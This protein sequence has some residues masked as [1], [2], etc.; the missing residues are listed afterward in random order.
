M[1]LVQPKRVTYTY[2]VSKE[3]E[4]LRGDTFRDPQ[5]R[6]WVVREVR[7]WD[8]GVVL[9]EPTLREGWEITL[10]ARH[11]AYDLQP[12]WDLEPVGGERRS[13]PGWTGRLRRD[14]SLLQ[15]FGVIQV[16]P[17]RFSWLYRCIVTDGN[18]AE[19]RFQVSSREV[20]SEAHFNGGA[21]D[22][23]CP[24]VVDHWA[25][26]GA[27]CSRFIDRVEAA[28]QLSLDGTT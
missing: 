26:I 15:G 22:E 6:E 2:I 23:T 24:D 16:G 10:E 28:R 13:G 7:A 12:G 4:V 27:S 1:K 17:Q 5:G 3:N 14:G 18:P 19:G 11:W 8:I 20:P 21:A 25:A 9:G